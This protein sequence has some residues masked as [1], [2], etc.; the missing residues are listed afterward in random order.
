[1]KR[2]FVESAGFKKRIDAEGG[3]DL[4]RTIQDE[5]LR[6]PEKG[7]IVS[8]TGGIRKIRVAKDGKGKSGSYRVFYL[9]LPDYGVTHLMF[10]LLKGE[11]AN[12]NKEE[13]NLL[14][15]KTEDIKKEAKKRKRS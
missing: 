10:L 1:M 11:R 12:I 15:H 5:I 3:K 9:D 2:R 13:K 8:G 6:N 14:K 4:L 7:D